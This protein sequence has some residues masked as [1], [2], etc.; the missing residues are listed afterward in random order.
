MNIAVIAANGRL[1]RAFVAEALAAGHTVTA[2]IRNKHAFQPHDRLKV[3][4][5]DAT[6]VTRLRQL[7]EGQDAVASAIGH[8]KGSKAD[9]QTVATKALVAAMNELSLRRFV[10]VTGTGVR[11]SGDRIPLIDR[12]ANFA[13]GRIDPQ[14]IRDGKNHAKVLQESDLEWTLVR[15]L[16]LQNTAAKPFVLTPHGPTKVFVSRTE[17]A[18]AMLQVLEQGTFVRQSP[19]LSKKNA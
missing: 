4:I 15:V 12:V 13:I 1:G 2:G 19:I 3:M 10:T 18:K 14:R 17:T 16:K 11:V 5:C 6:D 9:V 8:V 7:L